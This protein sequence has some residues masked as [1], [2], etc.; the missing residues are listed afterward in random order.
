MLRSILVR[1]AGRAH[2][3]VSCRASRLPQT[4]HHSASAARHGVGICKISVSVGRWILS[5]REFDRS[6]IETP[7]LWSTS[8]LGRGHL[9]SRHSSKYWVLKSSGGCIRTGE[10]ISG[11]WWRTSWPRRR[12]G[13]GSPRWSGQ[14]SA[15]W[16]SSFIIPNA[17]WVRSPCWPSDPDYQ[18]GGIGTALTEFALDRL[19]DAG[20]KVAMVETGGDPGHAAARRT[21]EKA[22]YVLLPIARYFKSL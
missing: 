18:G 4:T 17:A 20:M 2:A 1:T 3:G 22:G 8:R 10:K 14:P 6:K 12:G 11:V 9:S 15:S 19:E 13:Y 21:Y 5:S 7:K 16:R